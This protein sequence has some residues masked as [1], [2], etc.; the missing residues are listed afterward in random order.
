MATVLARG[1]LFGSGAT[2]RSSGRS[3]VVATPRPAPFL[4]VR[5]PR[6]VSRSSCG[7][8]SQWDPAS[9][10]AATRMWKEFSRACKPA[11][12]YSN[13]SGGFFGPGGVFMGPGSRKDWE[14]MM[15]NGQQQQ[16]DA[17]GNNNSSQDSSSAG[18]LALD[19]VGDELKYTLLA[20]VPGL[21]KPD[22]SIRLSKDNVLSISGERKVTTEEGAVLSSSERPLGPFQRQW[23]LP[24]D[25]DAAVISAKVT[26]GVLTI[27]VGRK[28]KEPEPEPEPDMEIPWLE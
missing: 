12:R 26:D 22:L 15:K 19:V 27:T 13:T 16:Q 7:G 28:V 6:P 4:R 14:E 11:G 25:A 3:G 18:T 17:Q 8:Y 20:D 2:W 21:A 10:D 24:E 1:Q 9:A 5:L 23:V